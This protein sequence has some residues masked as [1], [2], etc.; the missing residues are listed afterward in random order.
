MQKKF[1]NSRFAKETLITV[2]L[3]TLYFAASR[4]QLPFFNTDKFVVSEFLGA[5]QG[6]WE[7]SGMFSIFSLG[8]MPFVSSY[9]LIE[10]ASV[11]IPFLKKHRRGD[12]RGR[13]VL[14]GYALLLTLIIGVFQGIFMIYGLQAMEI[15]SVGPV[16][17]DLNLIKFSILVAILV[18]SMFAL[19]FVTELI[20]IYGIGNGISLLFLS[21]LAM[22]SMQRI[23]DIYNQSTIAANNVFHEIVFS[24][25]MLFLFI[26]IPLLLIKSNYPLKFKHKLSNE[27]RDFFEINLCTSGKE[28]IGWG[29]TFIS[30]PLTL[31]ILLGFDEL[32]DSLFPYAS[33]NYFVI[34][35][36]AIIF[37]SLLFGWMFFRPGKRFAE[38]Q[39]WG[40][41]LENKGDTLKTLERKFYIVSLPWTL[42]LCVMA[43]TPFILINSFDRPCYL[44]GESAFIVGVVCLDI[45]SRIDLWE[46]FGDLKLHK[47]AEFHDV[48]Y[49]RMI[50]NHLES[51]NI[52]FHLQGF[53]HRHLLYFLGPFIPINLKVAEPDV[54][55]A[56]EVIEKFY[57][58]LGA[59]RVVSTPE[60]EPNLG[61]RL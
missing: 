8:I 28:A 54:E 23:K 34:W 16:L 35:I 49:A 26:F 29:A 24:S 2:G 57:G 44:G 13:G 25:I 61:L 11:T 9:L 30:L 10:L 38:M 21:G 43:V 51:E 27:S 36:I 41:K 19:I 22:G 33:I 42:V 12:Y 53:Y 50:K 14:K 6:D 52:R 56:Y 60:L 1:L 55:R 7:T 59:R 20:T 45:F 18:S 40:W 32:A 31:S 47:I 48:Y 58:N 3:L 39:S 37:L 17:G 5:V 15:P 4:I 46:K